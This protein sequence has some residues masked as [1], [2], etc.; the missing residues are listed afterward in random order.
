MNLDQDEMDTIERFMIDSLETDRR[1]PVLCM[2]QG[3]RV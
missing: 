2:L 3:H 1:L